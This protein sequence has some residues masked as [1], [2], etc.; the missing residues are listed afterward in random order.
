M[1][2]LI[3]SLLLKEQRFLRDLVSDARSCV[4]FRLR[5][6]KLDH[7]LQSDMEAYFASEVFKAFQ[8]NLR[9]TYEND[10]LVSVANY[11]ELLQAHLI[12][13]GFK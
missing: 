10:T 6:H 4:A 7:I 12:E 3:N 9:S 5:K 13:A 1:F 2:I 11:L 8:T